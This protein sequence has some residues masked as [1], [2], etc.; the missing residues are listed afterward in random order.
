MTGISHKSSTSSGLQQ[1]KT[2]SSK[3]HNRQKPEDKA[4]K[5]KEIGGS[6]G[7]E[8]TRYGDWVNAN[9]RCSDF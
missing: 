5:V 4:H 8:P 6:K 1:D 7:P 9:G 2:E 3:S